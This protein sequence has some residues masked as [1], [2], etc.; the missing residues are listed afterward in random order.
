MKYFEDHPDAPKRRLEL[1]AA[2]KRT[3][4]YAEPRLVGRYL[5]RKMVAG[6]TSITLM[7][8]SIYL[9][10][11]NRAPIYA[12]L[13]RIASVVYKSLGTGAARAVRIDVMFGTKSVRLIR[14]GR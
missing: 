8:D 5:A 4:D 12:A 10:V 2:R 6:D 3:L 13:E 7:L 14:L 1:E 11:R 9:K